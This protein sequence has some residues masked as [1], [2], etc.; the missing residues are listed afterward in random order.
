MSEN[1]SQMVKES[2]TEEKDVTFDEQEAVSE[3]Q[4][5]PN[6]M[7]NIVSLSDW[8][9]SEV[10]RFPNIRKP[11]VTIQG[12]NPQEQLIITIDVPGSEDK[13]KLVIF[14]D[15]H[16][17]PV[18]DLPAIDMQIYNNGF[19]V[20][21]DYGGIFIKSYGIRTGII[22][23]FCHDVNDLFIPYAIT[24]SKKNDDS[25]QVIVED[26]TRVENKLTEPLDL[27]AL[28]LRYKQSYKAEGLQTNLDAVKWLIERQSTIADINHHLQIDN[29]IIETLA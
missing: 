6:D 22:S 24:K 21:Y 10:E 20:I 9:D 16:I 15:A 29:V 1:L 12:V 18:L 8:F 2:S 17:T 3:P 28:N 14:D 11:T 5:E 7:V 23:V 27:E 13:R 4:E 19:R 26:A 25:I